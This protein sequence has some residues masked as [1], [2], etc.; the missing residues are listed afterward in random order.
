M[1]PSELE[2]IIK[3]D[4]WYLQRQKGSHRIYV[5]PTKPGRVIIPWHNRDIPAGTLH[6]ILKA[7]D[8]K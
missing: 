6:N 3:A 7:A 2:S 8:I 5:H 4:G 1:K